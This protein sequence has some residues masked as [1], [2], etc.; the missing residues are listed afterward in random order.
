MV[1]MARGIEDKWKQPL[2]FFFLSS[3]CSAQDLMN[4]LFECVAKLFKVGAD[5]RAVI[6]DM[7]SNFIQ[8]SKLLGVTTEKTDF[9]VSL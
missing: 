3:T 4:I 6:T 2:G 5:V 1:V 7:G 8:F 9:L